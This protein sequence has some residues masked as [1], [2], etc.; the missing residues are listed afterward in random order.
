MNVQYGVTWASN[1][2]HKTRK[3][4]YLNQFVLPKSQRENPSYGL[5]RAI[6][7]ISQYHRNF[8]LLQI[9]VVK[10]SL[11]KMLRSC[12]KKKKT[13]AIAGS[14]W[15]GHQCPTPSPSQMSFGISIFQ[16]QPVQDLVYE[17]STLLPRRKRLGWYICNIGES[18]TQCALLHL[19]CRSHLTI[20]P[21]DQNYARIFVLVNK[22]GF[23]P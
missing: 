16:S 20:L 15:F 4:Y 12:K 18:Q 23:S 5:A 2:H 14:E 17:V 7:M 11:N 3:V 8:N 22:I 6:D 10:F 9:I 1:T 21:S 13:G 19:G